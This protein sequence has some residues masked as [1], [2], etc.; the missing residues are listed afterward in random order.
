MADPKRSIHNPLRAATEPV[1]VTIM[2]VQQVLTPLLEEI[3]LDDGEKVIT[4]A[5][6]SQDGVLTHQAF[7]YRRKRPGGEVESFDRVVVKHM[8][9]LSE[10]AAGYGAARSTAPKAERTSDEHVRARVVYCDVYRRKNGSHF[11]FRLEANEKNQVL[12]R[13]AMMGE[14]V[15]DIYVQKGMKLCTPAQ[16]LEQR[17]KERTLFAQHSVDV[18][19]RDPIARIGAA[20]V[21]SIGRQQQQATTSK[22]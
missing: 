13:S 8:V 17:R 21:E 12:S 16:Y 6:S 20:V 15:V 22:S 5:V 11:L 2:S 18:L 14:E 3:T 9:V 1:T 4:P 10:D 7:S 19:K